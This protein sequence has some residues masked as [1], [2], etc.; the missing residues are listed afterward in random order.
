MKYMETN[1]TNKGGNTQS[2]KKE[3]QTCPNCGSKNTY[4]NPREK[5]KHL[6]CNHCG[7]EQFG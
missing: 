7:Y 5:G 4:S 3:K 6:Y 1:V 2:P